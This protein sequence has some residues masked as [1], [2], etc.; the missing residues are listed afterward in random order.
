MIEVRPAAAADAKDIRRIHLAAF[1][2]TAEADL[3][4]RLERDA[5]S[6][7]SLVA[8]DRFQLVGHVL[9]SRMSVEGD[10]EPLLGVGLAPVAVV[11]ELQR[12]GIGSSLIRAGLQTAR[13]Q[14]FQIAFVLG[15]PGY[16]GRFGFC[17]ETAAPFASPYAGPYFQ[18]VPLREGFLAPSSGR[19][20]YAAAFAELE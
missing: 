9:F 20:D 17:A 4:D 8:V 5:A 1:A 7:I 3:V 19:A 12:Q 15:A 10:G 16:Y 14:G 18:A 2:T 11:P 13:W 6:I